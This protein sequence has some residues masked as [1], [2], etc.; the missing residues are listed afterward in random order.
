MIHNS[1]SAGINR[2]PKKLTI[3]M[4]IVGLLNVVGLAADK[5]PTFRKLQLSDKFYCEGAYY[6]DFNRD[7]KMDIV[8]GPFWYEGPDFQK[9]HEIRPP[10]EFDPKGYSDAFLTFT[11]DFNGDGW[12]DVLYVPF[13]GQDAYWYE[14]PGA[15][16]GPWKKHLALKNVGN[17]SPAGSTLMATAGPN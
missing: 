11:G 6:A 5:V 8:A 13:P 2:R 1:E 12:S 9:K 16:G 15:K 7:G 14:N 3:A 17:E 10:K 4:V